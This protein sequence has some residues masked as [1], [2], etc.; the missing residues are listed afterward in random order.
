M[1]VALG[2][3]HAGLGLRNTV[4]GYLLGKGYEVVDF[5]TDSP[6]STDY[7]IYGKAVAEAVASGECEFGVLICGTGIG[8]SIAA[9][10]VKGIRAAAC[11]D[12]VSASLSRR[13]NNANVIAFG[14]R[15]VGPETAL[16]ILDAFF[17]AEFE[18]GRHQRRIDEIADMEK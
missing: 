18:G 8:I 6:Q 1:K 11:S 10:K 5:G 14:A 3:D 15:I 16:A 13:H 17:E 2:N 9:N 12:P 4:I 7:P